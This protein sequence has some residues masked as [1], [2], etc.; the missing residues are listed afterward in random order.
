[1]DLQTG[2]ERAWTNI[3]TFVPNLVAFLLIL[4]IGYFVAKAIG[5]V[6]DKVLERVGFDRAVE[7]G[8]IKQAM[9]RSKYDAS[10]IVSKLVFYTLF[11]FVLQLAFGVFGPNPVSDLLTDVIAFLPNVFVAIV[12]I[13]IASAIAKAVNDIVSNAL[14]G[15]SYGSIV[16]KVASGFI[17]FFGI[18]AALN[19]IG[20]AQFITQ[21]LT[22]AL[23]V[24]LVG[25]VIVG[26]GGGLVKPMQSRWERILDRA[27]DEAQN[28]KQQVQA[29]RSADDPYPAYDDAP[30][31]SRTASSTTTAVYRPSG[32]GR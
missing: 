12:I 22:T 3:I 29:E 6:V 15:L 24:A 11:L 5:K 2:L 23:L 20:V 31:E 27:S 4:A 14:G 19:Q 16:A 7:R 10:D 13:V 9:A 28:A 25:T 26:V 8:G 17:L 1:M 30:A 18:V 21:A 32:S